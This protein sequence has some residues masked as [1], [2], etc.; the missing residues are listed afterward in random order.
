MAHVG[1]DERRGAIL[2]AAVRVLAREGIAAATTRKIAAEADVNQAMLG[3]YFGSKDELL[4]AVLS[5]MMRQTQMVVLAN[6]ST[7]TTLRGMI[8]ESITAFWATVERDPT[9]QIMQLELTLYALRQPESAWLAQQQYAGYEAVIAQ[10]FQEGCAQTGTPCAVPYDALA[11]FVM[12]GLDGMILQ[13]VSDHDVGCAR[14][15]LAQLIAA[16]T[17]L[18]EGTAPLATMGD[19]AV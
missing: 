9:I 3:Y 10:M 13:F 18:A 2:A 14:R 5:E 19:S 8:A 17:A 1:I 16:V 4:F 12:A 6:R 11:R 15:A 7:D